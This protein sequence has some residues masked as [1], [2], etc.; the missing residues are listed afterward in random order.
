MS[1]AASTN[2]SIRMDKDLKERADVFF[3]EIGMSLST[4]FNIFV[5]QTLRERG[6]PFRISLSRPNETTIAALLEAEKLAEDKSV[7]GYDDLDELF[8]ELKHGQ[9]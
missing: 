2:I 6:I 4:A 1:A 5:R 8:A 3:A 7:N 9:D